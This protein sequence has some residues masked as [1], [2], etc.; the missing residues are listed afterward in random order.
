MGMILLEEVREAAPTDVIGKNT[1]FVS[2]RE[3]VFVLQFV[4]ELDRH[5]VMMKPFKRCAYADIVV[6]NL[7]VRP[8]IGFDFGIENMRREVSFY[9]LRRRV[10]RRFGLFGFSLFSLTLGDLYLLVGVIG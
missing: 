1:L 6:L 7:E 10:E 3:P 9:L 5:N 2:I 8:V 4:K